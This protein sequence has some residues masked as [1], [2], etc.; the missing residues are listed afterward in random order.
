[1]ALLRYRSTAHWST[2]STLWVCQYRAS[3]SARVARYCCA[4]PCGVSVPDIADST[5][6]YASIA[7]STLGVQHTGVSTAQG[8]AAYRTASTAQGVAAYRIQY[9]T[10]RSIIP[11]CSTAQRERGLYRGRLSAGAKGRSRTSRSA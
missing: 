3:R 8:V 5:L 2:S 11:H 7:H 4:R 6:W 1:M 9:R 10:E